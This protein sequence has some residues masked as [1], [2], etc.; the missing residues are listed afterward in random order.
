[1]ETA[2]QKL[3]KR[4]EVLK[5]IPKTVWGWL[6]GLFVAALL[7]LGAF[8]LLRKLSA[9]QQELARL[10]TQVEQAELRRREAEYNARVATE[11]AVREQ[12]RTE[13]HAAAAEVATLQAKV[14]E[15]EIEYDAA[16]AR[17]RNATNWKQLNDL[18]P[19]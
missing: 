7:S 13:A 11:E 12:F 8:L 15:Q 3:E 1:M 4:A 10:R 14:R 2:L 5:T 17:I 18:A 16:E 19:K 9:N 6:V